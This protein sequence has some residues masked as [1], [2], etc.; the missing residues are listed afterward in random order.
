MV[1]SA[2]TS[3]GRIGPP[4]DSRHFAFHQSDP[5]LR[6]VIVRLIVACGKCQRQYD[7]TGKCPGR[8]F[9]CHCGEVV[10]IQRPK[11]HDAG[12]VRCSSCGAPR[13]EGS[14]ACKF[15]GADFTLHE[16]DLNTVCPQC[17]S[18]VSDRARF[19]HH[20]AT[21]LVPELAAG[22][23]TPLVCPVCREPHQLTS[24]LLGEVTVLECGRCVGL[25]LGNETFRQLTERASKEA[26]AVEQHFS[27]GDRGSTPQA[28]QQQGF[29]YRN[30]VVCGQMM[31]RRNYGRKSGVIIDVCRDHGVWFDADELPGILAW[32]RSGGLAEANQRR[33]AD[34]LREERLKRATQSSGRSPGLGPMGGEPQRADL[35]DVLLEIGSWIFRR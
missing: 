18:R 32:I 11:G 22:D 5:S 15:C 1:C 33:A 20:C 17:L 3:A 8:R 16:R 34:A 13:D 35:A 29:R 6:R 12:V 2:P 4:G 21:P 23:E 27:A 7:A 26:L 14:A 31:H 25:W 10:T 30:C 9:R 28:A 19:C 24:R